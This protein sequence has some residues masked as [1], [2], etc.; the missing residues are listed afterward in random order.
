MFRAQ[1]IAGDGRPRR[2]APTRPLRN[3]IVIDASYDA[4]RN[5]GTS[6]RKR[7]ALFPR[8]RG[9]WTRRSRRF[10]SFCTHETVLRERRVVASHWPVPARG[11]H[12]ATFLES[13]ASPNIPHR[14]PPRRE[15]LSKLLASQLSRFDPK[16][17]GRGHGVCWAAAAC[18]RSHSRPS[19]FI[20]ARS[21]LGITSSRRC[22]G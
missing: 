7:A 5:T 3:A 4:R 21:P 9:V 2:L 8:T 22:A 19:A 18:M 20:C 10:Q 13:R 16:D 12:G 1:P 14:S 11:R 17:V 15:S 6:A